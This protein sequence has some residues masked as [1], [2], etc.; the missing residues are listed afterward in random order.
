MKRLLFA[1]VLAAHSALAATSWYVD[2]AAGGSNNG[3]SW[4][5]AWTAFASINWGGM[6]SGDTVYIS[7]GSSGK[8]Y[9][10]SVVFGK[11][12]ITV[13]LGADA[14]HNG[15]VIIN[16]QNSTAHI[17]DWNGFEGTVD[18]I[19]GDAV[20]GDYNYGIVITNLMVNGS[21]FYGETQGGT[22]TTV[23]HVRIYSEQASQS[24]DDR[25]GFY[26]H[27][28]P[29]PNNH[30]VEIAYCWIGGPTNAWGSHWH[31][32]AITIYDIGWSPV[33]TNNILLH[34]NKVEY[35]HHDGIKTSGNTSFW[36][37]DVSFVEG[38]GHS[39][40]IIVQSGAN[41]SIYDNYIHDGTDQS[42]YL[43]NLAASATRMTNI[44][45]Y[46][47]IINRPSGN[48]LVIDNESGAPTQTA[49]IRIYNNTFKT[50]GLA[51]ISEVNESAAY[52]TFYVKNNIF[53]PVPGDYLIS[54]PQGGL[55]ELDYNVYHSQGSFATISGAN[56]S[57]L[58]GLQGA[59]WETHGITGDP[60][61]VSSTDFH[62]QAGDTVAQDNGTSLSAF[63]TTDKDGVSR[64][65]GSAWDIG[66]YEGTGPPDPHII[67]QPQNQTT[68][69][70]STAT[71]SVTASGNTALS[72]QWTWYS[73]NVSGATA[74]A[75]TTPV[76]VAG[77]NG[78]SVYVTVTDTHASLQSSTVTLTVQGVSTNF[79]A[80][81]TGNS[82]NSGTTLGSPWPLDYALLHVG[83]SNTLNV[84]D[85]IY[86]GLP[87]MPEIGSYVTIRAINKWAAIITNITGHASMWIDN[88]NVGVVLDGLAFK[89]NQYSMEFQS[90]N[91]TVR[92]C[93]FTGT[94]VG[95]ADGSF[96]SG[97][98][99]GGYGWTNVTIEKCLS[100]YNGKPTVPNLTH[101]HGVYGGGTNCTYRNNV[102][103]YNAG[104]GLIVDNH[105][106]TGDYGNRIYNNLAY[107]N[108][109]GGTYGEQIACYNDA[110]VAP[111]SGIGT[112]WIYGN[113]LVSTNSTAIFCQDGM[114]LL[115]NN[116][117][118][119]TNYGV[120]AFTGTYTSDV[121][122]G[123]YNLHPQA[124][125]LAN[126]PNDVISTSAANLLSPS[127]GLYWLSVFAPARGKALTTVFGP[128]DFF[129]NSQSSVTDIGFNQYS[130]AYAA[131]TR[132]LDPSPSS[133]ADYWATLLP[134]PTG[135]A[136]IILRVGTAKVGTLHIGGAP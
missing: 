123:D 78:S 80:S 72:Y 32:T 58:S 75:W 84:M 82:G 7:G 51:C 16:G 95:F 27:A 3:T 90:P 28:N 12:G 122:L 118:I 70:G 54:F 101:N 40:S 104:Y 131:D 91:G 11:S 112:N 29:V 136:I 73:T 13:R 113:T 17:F 21:G 116:I 22:G 31:A 24:A 125:A 25:G 18:G 94:G 127:T 128:V 52:S 66:A 4:A 2:N 96:A 6:S 121:I 36:S 47:N 8:V 19:K 135:G 41:C 134:P 56:Y 133:G 60:L 87:A 33:A 99:G 55:S 15:Q 64:P 46:N 26:Y 115:T 111:L 61:Y 92:N 77:N 108:Y 83:T 62:L 88:T 102:L 34:N 67:T 50:V 85:G 42:I 106:A 132:T 35:M 120:Q 126:G 68:T 114:I 89:N 76:V 20:S 57:A 124:M 23:R 14:G 93:W 103:R 107:G 43:D 1:F 109:G 81:P 110:A 119:S 63:F 38:S 48:G 39:D 100:E 49:N 9:T 71:F 37:N 74:S 86:T 129:G 5:N 30:P 44:W 69:P 117:I 59:G 45:V 10:G 53:G 130:T 65:Q 79:Y 105:K 98:D 97:I